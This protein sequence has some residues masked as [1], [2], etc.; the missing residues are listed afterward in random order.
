MVLKDTKNIMR[1]GSNSSEE[2]DKQQLQNGS[3][4]LLLISVLKF[5]SNMKQ[6]FTSIQDAVY[7]DVLNIKKYVAK[8]S[9]NQ[10]KTNA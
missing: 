4:V 7:T 5:R 9:S 6:R 2:T 1:K 8:Q 10:V 3:W